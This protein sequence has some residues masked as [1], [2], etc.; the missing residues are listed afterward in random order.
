V[1]AAGGI[2][3][4][5]VGAV[6]NATLGDWTSRRREARDESRA[7]RADEATRQ[8]EALR[9]TRRRGHDAVQQLKGLAIKPAAWKMIAEYGAANDALIG[10]ADVIRDYR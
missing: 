2:I 1:A 8:L 9:Q 6:L 3:G 10:D 7:A 4:V 5:A